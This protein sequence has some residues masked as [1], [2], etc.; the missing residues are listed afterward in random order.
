MVWSFII[1]EIKPLSKSNLLI[2]SNYKKGME[3]ASAYGEIV[4]LI[5]RINFRFSHELGLPFYF[6]IHYFQLNHYIICNIF[7]ILILLIISVSLCIFYT[8]CNTKVIIIYYS[9]LNYCYPHSTLPSLSSITAFLFLD[10]TDINP[11]SFP[12]SV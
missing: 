7:H 4:F 10:L 2:F 5:I 8:Y 9:C 3:N 12:K 11:N 6:F 1:L